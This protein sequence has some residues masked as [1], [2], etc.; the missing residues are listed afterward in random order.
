MIRNRNLFILGLL[1]V[2]IGAAL[3]H[4]DRIGVSRVL[5]VLPADTPSWVIAP[6][7]WVIAGGIC[8]LLSLVAGVSVGF[9]KKQ[10]REKFAP[11]S[12]EGLDKKISEWTGAFNPDIPLIVDFII[13]QAIRHGASD[14]HFDPGATGMQ[15]KYRREGMMLPVTTIEKRMCSS[16]VN[17]LKV[18]SNLVIYKDQ[19][20]QDGRF[21]REDDSEFESVQLQR[22]GLAKTDF[23]I[24]FMPTLH[25]ERIVIRILGSR[26]DETDLTSLG[27]SD[28]DLQTFRRLIAQPQGMII[29]T[30]PTGSGKT[31]TIF[32]A[33]QEI[34][35]Q[36]GGKRSIA[37]LEDPIEFDVANI[38][39]S[40]V[41]EKR[42][43]TFDKGLR[44]ILRQ[45]PDV[46]MVGE[47]RDF[48]TAKIAIQAGMTGH[49]LITTVHTGN[50]AAA[51]SRLSEMGIPTYSLNSAITAVMAQRLVRNICPHCRQPG[52]V[53]D[54]GLAIPGA[55]TAP[56]GWQQFSGKGCA[57]CDNT[58]YLGRTAIFEI[59]EVNESIRKQIA[60]G[61]GSEE[62]Y[63][64]ARQQGLK[65]L[66]EKGL[67]AVS[68]GRTTLQE[69]ERT[70]A[71]TMK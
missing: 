20:P 66:W 69:I 9:K 22:S 5:E 17:R 43:F 34:M 44:A 36:S 23:R 35:R 28:D 46:I 40:Q 50:S 57:I 51:F 16:I 15:V 38:N 67:D 6:R 1:L 60:A 37:T 19:T 3:R 7:T 55:S 59:L 39:Q 30:G 31:T 21:D 61:D 42:D 54:A 13:F 4:A 8:F 33:L 65:T 53:D 64:A 45:D 41:D 56:A 29:L 68:A 2:A 62:I 27:M 63:S 48:E 10:R 11:V 25:G 14:I 58:G 52:A 24:A 71:A 49:L 26:G 32:A 47:I 12:L 18:L 70:I